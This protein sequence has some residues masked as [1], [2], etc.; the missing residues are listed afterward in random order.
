VREGERERG[1]KNEREREGGRERELI[2]G[3]L[4]QTHISNY[5]YNLIAS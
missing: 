2:Y 3:I 4:N 5:V 1:G